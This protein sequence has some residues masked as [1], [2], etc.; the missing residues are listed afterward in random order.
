MATFTT[1]PELALGIAQ[2]LLKANVPFDPSVG[3]TGTIDCKFEDTLNL[4]VY[5]QE[6]ASL[7]AGG[8]VT[9]KHTDPYRTPTG[10]SSSSDPQYQQIPRDKL[11]PPLPPVCGECKGRGGEW[12]AGAIAHPDNWTDCPVCKRKGIK[13]VPAMVGTCPMT[14]TEFDSDPSVVN[15]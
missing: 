10:R 6:L 11:P 14:D 3:S 13:R 5:Q 12:L 7:R 15:E 2:R 1:T 9:R 4:A 8:I